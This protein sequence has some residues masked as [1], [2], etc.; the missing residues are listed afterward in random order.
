MMMMTPT[1]DADSCNVEP[2]GRDSATPGDVNGG[3]LEVL[4]EVLFEVLLE[5]RARIVVRCGPTSSQAKAG[6]PWAETVQEYG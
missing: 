6:K 3:A 2:C 4:F 5:Q 1:S